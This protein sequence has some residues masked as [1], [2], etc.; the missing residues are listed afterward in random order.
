MAY[1]QKPEIKSA[2]YKVQSAEKSVDIAKGGMFPRLTAFGSVGSGY[3]N[4]TLEP[5]G[6]PYF[7][8]PLPTGAYTQ[9]G[10]PVL[11]DVTLYNFTQT[12]FTDQVDNN[13]NESVGLSISIPIFNGLSNRT[14]IKR[15]RLLYEHSKYSA[16]IARQQLLKSIQQAHADA[17]AALN[18]YQAAEKN[19]SA[20]KESFRYT[21]RKYEAGLL[22]S[23]DYITIK[24]NHTKADSDLLQARYDFIFRLKVL[25]FYMGKPLV[26]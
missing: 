26:Y 12:P 21:E 6:A 1:D 22:N 4:Q 15:A 18:R 19:A 24:N 5:D 2:E 8:G 11:S 9:S 25:D 13:L 16:D 23:V 14:S 20:M 3:S 17:V 10:E 7:Q